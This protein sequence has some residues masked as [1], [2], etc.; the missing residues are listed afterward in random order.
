MG[1][2]PVAHASSSPEEPD[3]T[4]LFLE[5]DGHP[6]ARPFKEALVAD[7]I[8]FTSFAVDDV[9]RRVRTPARPRRPLHP[10][11]HRHGAGHHRGLRRHLRQPDPDR[12]PAAGSTPS[13]LRR[14][15]RRNPGEH[16]AEIRGIEVL[17]FDVLGTMV[18]EPG[19]LRAA[20]QEACTAARRG[21][22][23]RVRRPVAAARRAG[24]GTHPAGAA[25]VREHRGPRRRGRPARGRPRR[26]HRSG[27]R[28]PAGH[29]GAAPAPVARLRR[30]AGAARPAV[31]RARAVQ[32]RPHGPASTSTRMPGCAGIRPCPPRR[33]WPTS[34]RRRCTDSPS[35]APD[36]RRSAC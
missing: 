23:R 30:R 32:R 18:D 34:R 16:M 20:V 10:G 19:G 25:P 4:E 36:A 8:P 22:R 9:Q 12:D 1:E 24:A 11:T 27:G 21:G 29:G 14:S 2:T 6:A 5:P 28:G 17:V 31:P 26:S 33:P 35:T 7:G 3:G 15:F 13:N